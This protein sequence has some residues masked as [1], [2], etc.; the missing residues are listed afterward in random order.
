LKYDHVLTDKLSEFQTV[1]Y[2]GEV[3]RA[4]PKSLNPLT[5]SR[6]GGRWMP[7]NEWP[8]L[9]TSMEREG[10]LAEIS[11]HLSQHN[12]LPSKPILIN[13]LSVS[14]Q[15]MIKLLKIDLEKFG[16]K[17]DEYKD[18]N[19]EQTQQIGAA[20][21]FLGFDSLIVPSARWECENLVLFTNNHDE[22]EGKL[23]LVDS[24][25][26]DWI[27]WARINKFFD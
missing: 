16:V 19:L 14:T 7:I 2:E 1:H 18:I 15:K 3:Y 5:P 22:V 25:E 27:K 17:S 23:N 21:Q 9:Y 8:V 10:A 13:R 4:T 26:V 11:F 24:E 20:V 6:R 12:P